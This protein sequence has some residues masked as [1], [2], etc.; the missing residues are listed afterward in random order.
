[1][2]C[3]GGLHRRGELGGTTQCGREK[4]RGPRCPIGYV[5]LGLEEAY[6]FA[7]FDIWSLDCI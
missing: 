1:M 6:P 3:V 7:G 2:A 5:R 4:G